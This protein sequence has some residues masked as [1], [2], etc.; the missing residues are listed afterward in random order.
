MSKMKKT[1]DEFGWL[2]EVNNEGEA[3]I[4]GI[5][6]KRIEGELIIP[7]VLDGHLV[8]SIGF[9]CIDGCS[10]ITNVSIPESVN[11]IDFLPVEGCDRLNEFCVG[12]NNQN[13]K[14]ENGCLLSKDGRFLLAVPSAVT[15]ITIPSCVEV[16]CT[17]AFFDCVSLTN[18]IIPN[19]VIR[20]EENAF[21]HCNSLER[22]SF[23]ESMET[24]DEGAFNDCQNLK[25]LIIPKRFCG[26][27]LSSFIDVEILRQIESIV[28]SDGVTQIV[29]D[30][31]SGCCSLTSVVLPN[32]LLCIGDGAFRGCSALQ[33]ISL[34]NRLR[35]IGND[36]F[37]MCNSLRNIEIPASVRYIGNDAFCCCDGLADENGFVIVGNI[38]YNCV[39][40]EGGVGGELIEMRIPQGVTKIERSF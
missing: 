30:A 14:S 1:N 24:I 23:T 8:T 29:D 5:E 36:S 39:Q 17:W 16:V 27:R 28:I 38:L 7:S 3:N 21:S 2:Y 26:C 35:Y 31:F 40:P 32:S 20:I 12:N 18:V 37:A 4:T 11:K 22:I 6:N 15:S 9:G 19:G 34:P 10:L 25:R 33:N 13:Y